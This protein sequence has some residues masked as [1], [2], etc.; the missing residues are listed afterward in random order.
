M[1]EVNEYVSLHADC[2]PQVWNHRH[3]FRTLRTIR[4]C[5]NIWYVP[6]I[7][8]WSDVKG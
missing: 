2:F 3:A 1:D 5:L 6:Y 4:A 7:I 8:H